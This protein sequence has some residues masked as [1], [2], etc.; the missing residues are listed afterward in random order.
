[1]IRFLSNWAAKL[2]SG[3][4]V[5]ELYFGAATTRGGMLHQVEERFG[6]QMWQISIGQE[7]Q[8]FPDV[9]R[10]PVVNTPSIAVSRGREH[11][12]SGIDEREF[13]LGHISGMSCRPVSNV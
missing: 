1:M 8:W 11:L 9:E 13:Q 7:F 2:V 10:N 4:G 5:F 6:S 3:A 12:V